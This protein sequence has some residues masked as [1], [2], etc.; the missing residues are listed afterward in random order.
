MLNSQLAGSAISPGEPSLL[1][2]TMGACTASVALPTLCAGYT[3]PRRASR[4]SPDCSIDVFA[5]GVLLAHMFKATVRRVLC[6]VK[7]VPGV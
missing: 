6:W 2:G 7:L 1:V 4:Q 5:L 3:S